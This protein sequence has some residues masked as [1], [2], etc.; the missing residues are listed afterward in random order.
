MALLL[1]LAEKL[2]STKTITSITVAKNG[3][4]NLCRNGRTHSELPN[5]GFEPNYSLQQSVCIA[6]EMALFL[7][8]TENVKH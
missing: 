3:C 4:E 5:V 1:H 7:H 8:L 6:Y 2:Q